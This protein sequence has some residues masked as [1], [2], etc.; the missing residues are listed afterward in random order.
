MKKMLMGDYILMEL[1]G[2]KTEKG[3]YRIAKLGDRE[4]C[5]N[6]EVFIPDAI[7]LPQG[8]RA[9]STVKIGLEVKGAKNLFATLHSLVV[10]A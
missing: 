5:S 4:N 10:L 6:F 7:E 8:L 1:K 9:G 2:I 3:S